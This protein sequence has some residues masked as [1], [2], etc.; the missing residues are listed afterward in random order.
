[1]EGGKPKVSLLAKPLD[2]SSNDH[3]VGQEHSIC[4]V[5]LWFPSD[6]VS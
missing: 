4:A 5:K 6:W 3:T 2:W 1:M